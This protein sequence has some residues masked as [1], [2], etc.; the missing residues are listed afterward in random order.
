MDAVITGAAAT[1]GAATAGVAA[2]IALAI[3]ARVVWVALRNREAPA[4]GGWARWVTLGEEA[5]L[6]AFYTAA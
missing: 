4:R 2:S 6:E 3:A 5:R 1:I